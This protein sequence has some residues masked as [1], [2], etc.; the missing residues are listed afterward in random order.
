V[1]SRVSTDIDPG[2]VRIVVMGTSSVDITVMYV[3]MYEV[4]HDV[5]VVP[6]A[7]FLSGQHTIRC[8]ITHQ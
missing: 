5:K 6:G 8:W 4:L 7:T 3:V 2:I 1:V